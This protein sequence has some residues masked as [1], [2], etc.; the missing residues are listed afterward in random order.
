M[1]YADPQS[2]TIASTPISL[3]R[4]GNGIGTGTFS[5]NDGTVTLKISHQNGGKVTRRVARFDHSKITPDPL[6]SAAN[7]KSSMSVYLV[8]QVPSAGY[9]VAQ[10]KEVI[11]GA[12]AA[13][14]AGTGAANFTTKLLGGEN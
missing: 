1:A 12:L 2:V 5:S 8:V 10:Q 13:I 7:I 11:D 4:T 9:T 3:P 6:I 14:A